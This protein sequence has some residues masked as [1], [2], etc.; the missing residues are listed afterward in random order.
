MG[1]STFQPQIT[2]ALHAAEGR[3]QD[4][5]ED[6]LFSPHPQ[7]VMLMYVSTY[8]LEQKIKTPD[9]YI[10]QGDFIFCRKL[11]FAYF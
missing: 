7:Q 8:P 1:M 10:M 6:T 11:I 3:D 5:F 2:S 9:C 4:Y